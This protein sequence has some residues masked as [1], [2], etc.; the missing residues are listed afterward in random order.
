MQPVLANLTQERKGHTTTA[1]QC[2]HSRMVDEVRGA[3]GAKTGRLVCIECRA[4]FPDP[5]YQKPR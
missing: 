1:S 5:A 4:E 2:T 3:N